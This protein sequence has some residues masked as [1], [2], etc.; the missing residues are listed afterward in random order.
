MLFLCPSNLPAA[1]ADS[2]QLKIDFSANE[3]SNAS[4]P[5]PEYLSAPLALGTLSSTL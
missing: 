4:S 5:M 1:G 2:T 3:P